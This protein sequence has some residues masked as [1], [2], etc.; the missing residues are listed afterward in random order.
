M[1]ACRPKLVSQVEVYEKKHV[2]LNNYVLHTQHTHSTVY[3]L[4]M[5]P[6]LVPGSPPTMVMFTFVSASE[7]H[8]TWKSPSS[9]SLNGVLRSY[10]IQW[11]LSDGNN[12]SNVTVNGSKTSHKLTTG[13]M[14]F[15]E[16]DVRVAAVTVAV[17]P[18]SNWSTIRTNETGK[19]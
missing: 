6:I 3:L 17:G 8:I 2:H 15:T 12:I 4:Y 13:L 16:Y 18:F 14:H 10:I 19:N 7:I 5:F 11:R 1:F 9:E